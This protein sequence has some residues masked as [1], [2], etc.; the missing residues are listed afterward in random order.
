MALALIAMDY[1]T[2]RV[3]NEQS[4]QIASIHELLSPHQLYSLVEKFFIKKENCLDIGCG[5]GRDS[6]W[7]S[8]HS[9]N[10]IGIDASEGMLLEAKIRYPDNH[11]IK[12]SLP[13]LESQQDDI[14]SNIFCSAVLMHLEP[15]QVQCAIMNIIRVMKSSGVAILSFRKTKNRDNR[16]RGL[17]YTPLSESHFY[18]LWW[19]LLHCEKSRDTRE[20][21]WT[22]LVF[23]KL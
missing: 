22:N 10:T 18:N 8:L 17:L 12:D 4:S 19:E 13:I 23:K 7:L 14:Y 20:Y 15:R 5:M 1:E 6:H 11:F 3:Y 2:I 9:F 21:E 16:E